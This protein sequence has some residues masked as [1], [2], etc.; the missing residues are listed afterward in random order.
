[1]FLMKKLIGKFS[2]NRICFPK[3]TFD[4]CCD[5]KNISGKIIHEV[6]MGKDWRKILKTIHK[7]RE[8]ELFII[9]LSWLNL[10]RKRKTK[11]TSANLIPYMTAPFSSHFS[12]VP[13]HILPSPVHLNIFFL[14]IFQ[15]PLPYLSCGHRTT[16]LC[17]LK[18]T[19]II[20]L[21]LCQEVFGN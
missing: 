8:L 13:F 21:L 15:A 7:Y 3:I 4:N 9:Y 16:G 2:W 5:K 14:H 17:T 18:L 10:C 11:L 19:V 1:M 20:A 12:C 6:Y